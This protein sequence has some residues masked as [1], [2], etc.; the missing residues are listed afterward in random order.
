MLQQISLVD[1]ELS[2]QEVNTFRQNFNID[3]LA[4]DEL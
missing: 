4:V 1:I 2:E 3:K